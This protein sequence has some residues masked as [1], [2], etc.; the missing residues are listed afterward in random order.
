M[1]RFLEATEVNDGWMV[2]LKEYHHVRTGSDVLHMVRYY[3]L[4]ESEYKMI[5]LPQDVHKYVNLNP[6]GKRK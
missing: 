4:S 6:K 3:N 2:I 1:R 5:P